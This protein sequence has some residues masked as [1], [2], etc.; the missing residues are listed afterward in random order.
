MSNDHD[1]IFKKLIELFFREFLALFCPA[2]AKLIDFSK[3]EFLREE[4]FTDVK[5]GKRKRLDLVVK[6]G[7]KTGGAKL[8]LVHVEFE[9]SRK[10]ED[11]PRRMFNYF[12]QLFL[13]YQTEIIPIA[14]FSDDAR[15]RKPVPNYFEVRLPTRQVVHFQYELIKLKDLDYRAYLKS[16]NPLAYALMAKMNY[17]RKERVRLK[18]DFLR[19]ILGTGIDPARAGVLREFVE[20]YMVLDR[21]EEIRFKQIVQTERRYQKVEKMI[22]TYEKEAMKKGRV[23]GR[24]EG[25]RKALT[26]LLESKFGK[27]SPV[28]KKKIRQLDSPKK[29]ES[30]LLSVLDATSL[31]ELEL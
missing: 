2:E 17:N 26:L 24:A 16:N 25:Q 4:F 8:I 15:W 23:E 21:T 29:L 27:L 9:A 31:D 13:R 30:L 10:P 20:T 1:Q 14:V 6:V 5:R 18:A 11:F 19:L 22:T 12:C 28:V 7:L 3:V